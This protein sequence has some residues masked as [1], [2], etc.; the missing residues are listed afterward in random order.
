MVKLDPI[1]TAKFEFTAPYTLEQ[2]GQVER[3]FAT[4]Y[5][6]VRAMLNWAKLTKHLRNSLWAQCANTASALENVISK[7]SNEQSAAQKFYGKNPSW[8]T[9]LR[10]FGE[11][12]IVHDGVHAKIRGNLM[13][14]WIPC[15]FIG[16]SDNHTSNVYQ[17]LKLDKE[18]VIFSRNVIWLNKN[19]GEFKNITTVNVSSIND[20][21]D[22]LPSDM[23]I[24]EEDEE[25]EAEEDVV[26]QDEDQIDELI[27]N[28]DQIVEIIPT[29]LEI[30]PQ[31]LK[32]G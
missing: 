28:E 13:D 10:I 26:M 19:Y 24:D 2:N 9:N 27:Q 15:M 11:I 22:N 12:G 8:T 30:L 1:L 32:I 14:R 31:Q 4:L 6:K 17:F 18:T 5:G 23:D 20:E 21:N 3:K 16:Y 29:M 7:H 25:Y